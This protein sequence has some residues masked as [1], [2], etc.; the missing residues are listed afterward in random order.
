M[1]L[2]VCAKYCVK[3]FKSNASAYSLSS[4]VKYYY[5]LLETLR[6]VKSLVQ[7]HTGGHWWRWDLNS[8]G[9]TLKVVFLTTKIT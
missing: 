3:L 2:C 5:L 8:G 9:L 7:S 4:F 6:K 1:Q